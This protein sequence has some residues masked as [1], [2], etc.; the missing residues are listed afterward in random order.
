MEEKFNEIKEN[1]QEVNDEMESVYKLAIDT[2][3][4]NYKR[5]RFTVKC[6][7]AIIVAL[8]AINGF[9]AYQFVTTT[10][11]E[12]EEWTQEGDYNMYNKDGSTMTNGELPNSQTDE[13]SN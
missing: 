13:T 12:T 1:I 4:K 6:L 10:V 11:V 7:L 8:L 2:M 9:L 5:E 3:E